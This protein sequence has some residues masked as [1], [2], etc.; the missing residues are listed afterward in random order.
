M[1]FNISE[2]KVCHMEN[3]HSEVEYTISK[4]S[5]HLDEK[6]KDLGV[7]IH[8][9]LKCGHHIADGGKKAYE[10]LGK[11]KRSFKC[12]SMGILLKLYKPLDGNKMHLT[13][14]ISPL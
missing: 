10:V 13:W 12:H 1:L 5:L 2:Y 7:T 8:Q 3:K 6:E 11:I 9:S 4:I 14:P